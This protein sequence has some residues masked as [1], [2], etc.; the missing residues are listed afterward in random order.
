MADDAEQQSIPSSL[1]KPQLPRR[2]T[3]RRTMM[4]WLTAFFL[5]EVVASGI[6]W[7][8]LLQRLGVLPVTPPGSISAFTETFQDNH[9]G[10]TVGSLGGFAASISFNKYLL[11]VS[12]GNT[13]F[14]NPATLGTLPANFTLTAQIAQSSGNSNSFY[15]LAF[16][17]KQSGG[18]VY[19]YAFVIEGN[20]NYQVVKYDP[21]ASRGFGLLFS[22]TQPLSAI[23][24]GLN[25]IN[26]LQTIVHGN[27]FSFKIND[28][29]VPVNNPPD[30]TITDSSSPYTGGKLALL[31]ASLN[32][33][34]TVTYVQL[35]IP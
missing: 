16:R 8:T 3:S 33:Q 23:K 17:F 1:G 21:N 15:G 4:I 35:T 30:Q 20:G 14:P 22:S 13:Y 19:C 32:T 5:A 11:T 18:Q 31:V 26:T 7:P 9:L 12:D 24:Q 34:F 6:T 2:G 10:W 28:T 27:T 29:L 25:Q